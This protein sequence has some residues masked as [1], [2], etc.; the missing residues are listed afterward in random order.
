MMSDQH[1]LGSGVDGQLLADFRALAEATS[2]D[3][4]AK[5]SPLVLQRLALFIVARSSGRNRDAPLFELC[6]LINIT[7]A[8]GA[9]IAARWHFFLGGDRVTA[10]GCR[11]GLEDLLANVG[12]RRHGFQETE[13]G[14]AISYGEEEFLVTFGRMPFL[15]A[16]YEFLATMDEFAY[17]GALNDTLSAML[18][19]AAQN[20]RMRVIQD[21]ANGLAATMRR[22]RG[23]H[24]DMAMHD[25]AFMA[26]LNYLQERGEGRRLD[27]VDEDILHFWCRHNVGEFRTYRR[28]YQRFADFTAALAA[29]QSQRAAEAAAPLGLDWE[30]GEV[31]PEDMSQAG[32]G[33]GD[34][35]TWS[36]PLPLLDSGPAA[37]IKFFTTAGEREP[38]APLTEF[39]PFAQRLPLAF[40]RYVAFGAV[41]AAI[42]TALQF[43]PGESVSDELLICATAESYS[44]RR[45]LYE[46]LQQRLDRLEKATYHAL[47]QA[48]ASRDVEGDNVTVLAPP[49]AHAIFEAA[50]R[51]MDH[52]DGPS[53]DQLM[54]L[55]AEAARAFK[56]ITRRGF[57][58]EALLDEAH[59]E[60]FRIGAGVLYTVG[61]VLDGYLL[62]LAGLEG[63][64][65]LESL[66]AADTAVFAAQFRKLY[67]VVDDRV[68]N[69]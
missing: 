18:E 10:A 63:E 36:D 58:A 3:G 22:Y 37:A 9:D 38:L 1:L 27:F 24:L 34:L 12:W 25:E 30:A 53:D 32:D 62:R 2:A 15:L 28:A 46:K 26:I 42:T 35:A 48:S 67:G 16:V 43:H 68:G 55:E 29:S 65:G 44:T 40:L 64:G 23:L 6:H 69:A 13:D 61:K 45:D 31:E 5:Y 57:E 39:G 54:A 50:R 4:E 60:G 14:I 19:A 17:H 41:Q 66:F 47:R 33:L 51:D 20:N 8:A 7:D 49:D 56:Q 52:G 59:Q 21:G 11:R